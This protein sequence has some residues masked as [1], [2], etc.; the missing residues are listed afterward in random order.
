MP[1]KKRDLSSPS[2]PPANRPVK[3]P[4]LPDPPAVDWDQVVL[5]DLPEQQDWVPPPPDLSAEEEAR[6]IAHTEDLVFKRLCQ[7]YVRRKNFAL[8]LFVPL[9][10][11]EAFFASTATVRILIGGNRGGKTVAGAIE[12][13][14]AVLGLDP[15]K[16]YPARDGR[17][18]AVGRDLNHCGK[19][20]WRKLSRSGAFRVIR[21]PA[22]QLLRAYDPMSPWDVQHK[23][24][25][26]PSPPLIPQSKIKHISWENKKEGIPKSVELVTG[27]ELTFF[28][29][30]GDP[31]QGWDADAAWFDEEIEGSNWYPEVSMRML[32]REGRLYWTATPQA[33]TPELYAIHD[34]AQ[35][36]EGTPNP[37]HQE[38]F[39]GLLE[40][41][42]IS[43]KMKDTVAATLT[44]EEYNV[45]VLGQF[46][47][48]GSRIY[49]DLHPRGIHVIESQPVPTD[50]TRYCA[51]DPGRQVCAVLFAAVP[52]ATHHLRGHVVF[53]DELYL[54][55][56][57]AHKFAE[58]MHKRLQGQMIQAWWI[59]HRAGRMTEIASGKT[60][61]Q[62]YS[63]ELKAL[64]VKSKETGFSFRAGSDNVAGRIEA[65]RAG[66]R[67]RECGTP[68]FLFM[69]E[70]LPN[71]MM[72]VK[73]Y[74][75]K[76]TNGVV[77]DEPVKV[78]DHLMDCAGYLAMA[79][80]PYV[81]PTSG[82]EEGYTNKILKAKKEKLRKKFGNTSIRVW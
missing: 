3:T 20:M 53:Y 60:P 1:R 30:K 40:N 13:A 47:I 77:T 55:A 23:E 29:G 27:W 32:D 58:A 50:W 22:T 43:Q 14:R 70:R 10:Q 67:I 79:R 15:N 82:V 75:Y 6:I 80:L 59:D 35:E 16:K 49:P 33:G 19:V 66:L 11:Q 24:Q 34:K 63:A 4:Y 76:K 57:D 9:P 8:N 38:F 2:Q 36:E 26:V 73:G 31:P 69:G 39:V 7:E 48:L 61:E 46:A 37:S 54:R 51:I 65:F 21:D 78:R 81:R 18:I 42:H 5:Q 44:G 28:S 74:C 62:Q 45:R 72:E 12:C 17:F 56:C 68:R 71:F 25:S 64:G 41:P 52:P